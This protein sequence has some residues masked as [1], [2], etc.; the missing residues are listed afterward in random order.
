MPKSRRRIDAMLKATIA[1][2]AVRKKKSIAA[3]AEEHKIHPNQI[4]AWKKQL[5]DYAS[6]VFDPRARIL[7]QLEQASNGAVSTRARKGLWDRK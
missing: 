5:E 7:V 3:I 4:Y 1:L 2:E 6:C